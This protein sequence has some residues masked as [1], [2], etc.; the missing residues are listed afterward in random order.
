MIYTF[1]NFVLTIDNFFT[2]QECEEVILSYKRC[3][4]LGITT[5]RKQQLNTD[6]HLQSD[7]Q[8]YVSDLVSSNN[9]PIDGLAS[10]QAFTNK[11]WQ[12][13]Y[14]I[15]SH[16]YSILKADAHHT[17]RLLKFQKTEVGEGY[18]Q[19]HHEDDSPE[20][21]RRLLT[22][23]LYLND[24]PEGGETEFLY[25]PKRVN[26]E[27]GKMVVWPAGFPHAH[28]GNPPISN[29]KYILTGWIEYS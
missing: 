7:D 4:D 12:I 19:W 8:L 10:F 6:A 21:M 9:F 17:C 23:I 26:A 25:Y 11:F 16:K 28:R 14:P 3:A 5:T 24:V 2:Q 29:V 1:E 20:N 18:H 15:Y 27:M 22:F 13:A